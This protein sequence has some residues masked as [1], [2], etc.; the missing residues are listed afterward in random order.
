MYAETT[1]DRKCHSLNWRTHAQELQTETIETKMPTLQNVPT[2]QKRIHLHGM[3]RH[4]GTE[5]ENQ[6]ALD[7]K[8]SARAD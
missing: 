1:K 3:C 7:E 4:T 2:D 5:K 6:E 8:V